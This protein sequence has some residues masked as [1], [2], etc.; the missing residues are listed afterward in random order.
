MECQRLTA[1]FL[2]LY[3]S[4]ARNVERVHRATVEQLRFSR[5]TSDADDPEL[6]ELCNSTD[7]IESHA[8]LCGPIEVQVVLDGDID[9]IRWGKTPVWCLHEV[10]GRVVVAGFSLC[11]EEKA[12][13]GVVT[14]IGQVLQRLKRMRRSA[15]AQV[16]LDRVM[17]PSAAFAHTDEV[18][19]EA[20]E[21]AL[22]A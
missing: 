19:A 9:Q 2:S 22:R 18:D 12:T 8:L 21:N 1:I 7:K 6:A 5:G 11:G 10:V 3:M 20:T 14:S 4:C 13:V 16:D 15:L 17:A